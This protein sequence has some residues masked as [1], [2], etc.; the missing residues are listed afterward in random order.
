[1]IDI[2]NQ[3]LAVRSDGLLKYGL[4]LA[5]RDAVNLLTTEYLRETSYNPRQMNM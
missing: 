3:I 1:M 5:V 2:E 4:P